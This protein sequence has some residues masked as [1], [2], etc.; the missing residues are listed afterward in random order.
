MQTTLLTERT[1][2]FSPSIKVAVV[3][4]IE[5]AVS[6]EQ[7]E[8]AIREAVA[9]NEIL[10]STIGLDQEGNACYRRVGKPLY[11]LC[12]SQEKWED[13]VGRQQSIACNLEEGPLLDC[14]V[15]RQEPDMQLL[16][17]AHHLAGDGLS[18][19][20]LVQDI[21]Q[22]LAGKSVAFK[23]LSVSAPSSIGDAGRL[24]PLMRFLLDRQNRSWRKTGKVFLFPDYQR[25]VHSY[26]KDRHIQITHQSVQAETLAGL[27]RFAKEENLTLNSIITSALFKVKEKR[28]KLGLAVSVRPKECK[29]M[30]NFASGI[31]LQYRYND[32]KDFAWNAQTIQKLIQKKTSSDD[33]KFFLLRFLQGI[34]PT[35]IDATYFA[36]YDGYRNS[37]A[38]RMQRMFGY[39]GKPSQIGLSNLMQL[40]IEEQYGAYRLL[41]FCFVPPLVPN[42]A[43]ILGVATLGSCMELSLIG[44]SSGDNQTVLQRIVQELNALV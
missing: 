39:E 25:M 15:T 17:V 32:K 4:D 18:M 21:M 20:L 41:R 10:C 6:L 38:K 3:V 30:G 33:A 35:L 11:T 31:S 29:A 2:L 13:L 40:P 24:P 23:P 14:F 9:A 1:H 16:L 43:S 34:D 44:E 36:A 26:W 7:L 22:A 12:L 27:L 8:A 42:N 37:I 5:A 19:A 28:E